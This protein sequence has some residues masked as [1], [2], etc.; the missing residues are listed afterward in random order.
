[1]RFSGVLR[2]ICQLLMAILLGTLVAWASAAPIVW[3]VRDGLGPDGVDSGW[4]W[5]VVKFLVLWGVPALILAVPWFALSR[6]ERRLAR[7]VEMQR[8][9]EGE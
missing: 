2:F 3:I 9:Q 5:S 1:M 7:K 8:E 4:A 6:L